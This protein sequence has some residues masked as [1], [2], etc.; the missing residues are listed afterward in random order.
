MK[1][2]NWKEQCNEVQ[3]QYMGGHM[4]CRSR[5]NEGCGQE[6]MMMGQCHKGMKKRCCSMHQEKH[7]DEEETEDEDS[8]PDADMSEEKTK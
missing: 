4:G 7:F 6:E 1:S 2:G 5:M 3:N 8:A